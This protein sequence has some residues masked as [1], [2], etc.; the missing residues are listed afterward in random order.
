MPYWEM[1]SVFIQVASYRDLE[2]SKTIKDAIDKSSKTC[3]LFFGV[4]QVVLNESPLV[5]SGNVRVTISQAPNNIG[6]NV[7][8]SLAN[9]FYAGEDY[10]FQIDSHMRF[11]QDW[12]TTLIAMVKN[13]QAAGISKPLVTMYPGSYWYKD[14]LEEFDA[15]QEFQPTKV[16]F[17]EKP[18][19]FAE[20]LIPSQMAV[21][22][23][24]ECAYTFSVSGANIFTLGEFARLPRDNRIA[25]WGE[26]ILTAATAYCYGFDLVVSTSYTCWHLYESG[27]TIAETGR[28]HA[29]QDFPNEW[30]ALLTRQAG[31]VE[32]SLLALRGERTLTDFGNF[33]GLD[34]ETRQIIGHQL[35]DTSQ[36]N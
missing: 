34:F 31:A 9:S 17:H 18:E 28:H 14:G 8:R 3:E 29:W 27:Q 24:P 23:K 19:Q 13:Y 21:T 26:E 10:Y 25:F 2:L 20:T 36:V 15:W 22:T 4:H 12:D 5:S 33:A 30:Q 6:V 11:A 7:G 1:V 35:P 32:E 16:S